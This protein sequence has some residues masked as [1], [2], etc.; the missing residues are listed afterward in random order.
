MII[1]SLVNKITELA[2]GISSE[3][4]DE[5]QYLPPLKLLS[6][7][8]QHLT[9]AAISP[10]AMAHKLSQTDRTDLKIFQST[11]SQ[12]NKGPGQ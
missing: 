6:L 4:S 5:L 9:S 1:F 12:T 10:P 8:A 2:E 7:V 3:D 11:E